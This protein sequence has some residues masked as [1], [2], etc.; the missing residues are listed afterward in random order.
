MEYFAVCVCRKS[1][2]WMLLFT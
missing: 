2:L 1:L